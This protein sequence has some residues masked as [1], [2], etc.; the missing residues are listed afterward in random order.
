MCFQHNE[1][2][3]AFYYAAQQLSLAKVSV[4]LAEGGES[5][6][7]H[8]HMHTVMADFYNHTA[9]DWSQLLGDL[10]VEGTPEQIDVLLSTTCGEMLVQH[11]QEM[12]S[13]NEARKEKF[14]LVCV[15][16]HTDPSELRR[17]HPNMRYW[18]AWNKLVIVGLSDQSVFLS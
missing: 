13:V 3:P 10:A 18:A 4:Y 12:I 15:Q 9:K 1:V 14:R 17:M 2:W 6:L 5:H 7:E 11:G 16:H 8:N